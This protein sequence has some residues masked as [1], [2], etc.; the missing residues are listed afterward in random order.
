MVKRVPVIIK[1]HHGPLK[2]LA[3]SKKHNFN[4]IIKNTPRIAQ[5]IKSLFKLIV[6]PRGPME[7]KH[8]KKLSKHKAFIRKV[9]HANNKDIIPTIQKGGSIFKTILNVALPILSS[10]FSL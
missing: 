5:A 4:M 2:M 6:N 8:L 1:S 10:L 3:K 7:A 9:A